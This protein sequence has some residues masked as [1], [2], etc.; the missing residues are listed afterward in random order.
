MDTHRFSPATIMQV[1]QA[2]FFITSSLTNH[3]TIAQ[4]AKKV[5]LPPQKLKLAFK[6]VYGM[7]V[8]TYLRTKR[9][10]KAQTMLLQGESLNDIIQCIG[11]ETKSNFCKAFKKFCN[12]T[13]EHWRRRGE[14]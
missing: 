14:V 12:E 11:F 5:K 13:P 8:Y 4:I 3:Y 6:H 10:E 9:M 2:A 7:G 1:N